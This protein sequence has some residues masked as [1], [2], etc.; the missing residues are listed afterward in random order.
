MSLRAVVFCVAMAL[1]TAFASAFPSAAQGLDDLA[2]AEAARLAAAKLDVAA[3]NLDAAE[4]ARDR[5]A[6]LTETVQAFEDGLEALRDGVRRASLRE[7]QLVR[8]LQA[9]DAE[10]ANLLGVLPSMS[11]APAPTALLHP[12]GP[13]G[14]ARAG[15]IVADV[16]PALNM[17]AAELRAKLEEVHTL[18]LLQQNAAETLAKGLQGAQEARAELSQA[19]SDRVPL[20]KK[21]TEDPVRTAI[22]ISSAET[23]EGFASGLSEMTTDEAEVILEDI[24]AQR[25]QLNLPVAGALLRGANEADAAGVVRPG[26]LLATRARALVTAP[27]AATIRYLGPLLDYGN[28]IILE[29][30][31]GILFVLAGLDVVYGSAG[32]VISVESP[33]GLM[34]GK[35]PS[36]EANLLTG[37]EGTGSGRPETLYIEIRVDNAPVDPAPWFRALKDE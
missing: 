33:L 22:L 3:R 20:P 34:G 23:L 9:R 14:T 31:P 5:V 32:D 11:R 7:A 35:E 36:G 19:I 1:C 2:A 29:P 26:L 27:A 18:R 10:V 15:M 8:D 21:F 4:S 17:R 37:A 13:M 24:R 16:A 28:V 25:G 6:A 12:A 30:G